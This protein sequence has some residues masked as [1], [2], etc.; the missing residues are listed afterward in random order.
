MPENEK[1]CRTDSQT[2]LFIFGR[3]LYVTALERLPHCHKQNMDF[4]KAEN[5]CHLF[6]KRG[7]LNL[8]CVHSVCL[9]TVDHHFDQICTKMAIFV[10]F[11]LSTRFLEINNPLG[12]IL[13]IFTFLEDY[14]FRKTSLMV[15]KVWIPFFENKA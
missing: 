10:L 15:H 8:D 14:H 7:W 3:W 6:I 4:N 2:S 1:R 5:G 12:I 9:A 13:S 11:G